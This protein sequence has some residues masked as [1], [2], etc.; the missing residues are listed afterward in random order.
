MTGTA[1]EVKIVK[2]IDVNGKK[3]IFASDKIAN[4][5]KKSYLDLVYKE[6]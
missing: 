3:I 4:M 6:Y 1:L 2:S 5:L